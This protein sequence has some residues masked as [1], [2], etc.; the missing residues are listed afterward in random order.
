MRNALDLELAELGITAQQWGVL[1]HFWRAPQL[2]PSELAEAMEV[3]PPAATRHL[4]RL[5][6]L[7][8]VQRTRSEHDGRSVGIRLTAEGG[9]VLGKAA[10]CADRVTRGF[11]AKLSE[12]EQAQL[13]ALLQ[14]MSG[15]DREGPP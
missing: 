1:T 3:T 9:R 11:T 10:I 7:G 8:L 13:V 12:Q 15:T 5:E 6:E 4:H 2:T 14:R